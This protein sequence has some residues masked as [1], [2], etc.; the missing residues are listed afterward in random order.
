MSVR[1]HRVIRI[2]YATYASFN[3]W[4]D[5]DLVEFLEGE[6]YFYEKLD[7]GG[8]GMVEIPVEVLEKALEEASLSDD[9]KKAVQLDVD[10]CKNAGE[11]F[12]LYSCF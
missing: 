10:Y 3:L 9:V 5:R 2:E 11:E 8:G 4:H 12:V 1:A 6:W 7:S